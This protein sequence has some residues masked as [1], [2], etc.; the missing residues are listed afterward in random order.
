[1]SLTGWE[2]LLGTEDP[3]LRSERSQAHHQGQ[4][5]QE[6]QVSRGWL[7]GGGGEPGEFSKPD[8]R[9]GDQALGFR[10]PGHQ[11]AHCMNTETPPPV[12]TQ[13]SVDAVPIVGVRGGG[14]QEEVVPEFSASFL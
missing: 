10:F 5:Q 13:A 4:D 2:V 12:H 3:G 6:A 1:M 14:E 11:P 9:F 7:A 8:S